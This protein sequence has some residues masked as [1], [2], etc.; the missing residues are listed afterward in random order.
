MSIPRRS[1]RQADFNRNSGK[2][3]RHSVQDDV[4]HQ[5]KAD[6]IVD[7]VLQRLDLDHDGRVT[8]EELE[9]VGLN[10][11]P[12]F[13][14]L[15]AEGHHYDVESGEFRSTGVVLFPILILPIEF[16][17]HHEGESHNY[18]SASVIHGAA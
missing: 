2:S 12:N 7:T 4:E 1:P 8:P 10:G 18:S 6:H 16:F 11:L 15:G 3:P 17:L 5:K 13:N 14:D 9:R